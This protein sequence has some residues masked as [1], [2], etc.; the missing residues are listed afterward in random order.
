MTRPLIGAL[1]GAFIGALLAALLLG[2]Q[3]APTGSAGQAARNQLCNDSDPTSLAAVATDLDSIDTTDPTALE[4]ALGTT[5]SN[6]ESL[7]LEPAAQPLR[8]AAA[9]AIQNL[10]GL[11][12]DPNARQEAA[13]LAARALRLVHTEICE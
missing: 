2:C 1:T 6:L 12:E 5:L 11:L 13:R 10:Q 3:G 4:A 9:T 7:Q 8:D